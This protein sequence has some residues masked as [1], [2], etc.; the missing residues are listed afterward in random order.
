MNKFRCPK[1]DVIFKSAGDAPTQDGHDD[2]PFCKNEKKP[3]AP[4]KS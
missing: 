1:H 2:C 4:A 3:D